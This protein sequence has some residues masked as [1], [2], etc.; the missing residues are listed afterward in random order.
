MVE[1]SAS[2]RCIIATSV[3][4]FLLLLIAGCPPPPPFRDARAAMRHVND[5]L[6]KIDGA[7]YCN[8]S[9]LV[10]FR[11]RDAEERD[12]RFIGH[13][14]TVIFEAP[15][16]LY[17][18]I[19]HSLG[20]SVAHIGSNDER[21]W[22]WVDTPELRKLWWGYWDDED[23]G[24]SSGGLPIPPGLLLDALLMRPLPESVPGG[25]PPLMIDGNT[26]RL[27]FQR[28][29]QDGWPYVAREM[30]LDKRP[31]Y[32]PVEII[33]RLSDGRVVMQARI[34]KYRPVKDTGKDGPQTARH[35][36]VH[37]PLNEAEMRLDLG[38]VRYR[39]KDVPF[40]EFPE[41]WQ[42]EME[43]IDAPPAIKF[44]APAEEG[45]S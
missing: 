11:F 38:R 15:R 23:G 28:L 24:R 32:Q 34:G 9:A 20:G 36:V 43:Q 7:L 13:P 41:Y 3:C 6:T 18:D 39:T 5:N 25:L 27:L 40:C 8:S 29:G 17:F 22:V 10:S 19:K 31:P 37:W 14:T 35:Y 1:S 12:R 44:S 45:S 4:V 42:G 21:Y 30:V 33:D 26:C 2:R 16:C